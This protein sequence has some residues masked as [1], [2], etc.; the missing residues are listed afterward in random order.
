MAL[1]EYDSLLR[2]EVADLF[3]PSI[4]AAIRSI[5]SQIHISKG[6]VKVNLLRLSVNTGISS[7]T[8]CLVGRWL[9]C[10]PLAFCP[11]ASTPRTVE[12]H[13]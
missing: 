7:R 6:V 8:V 12:R 3:E 5:Q 2:D 13:C 9:C 4:Q 11:T 1:I 10:Q